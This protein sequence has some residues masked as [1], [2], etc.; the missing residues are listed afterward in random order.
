ML[1]FDAM[2]KTLGV[3]RSDPNLPHRSNLCASW[4]RL[5][6][7]FGASDLT[8]L[9]LDSANTRNTQHVRSGLSDQQPS[10]SKCR[11]LLYIIQHKSITAQSSRSQDY[12]LQ[13]ILHSTSLTAPGPRPIVGKEN[14]CKIGNV[15]NVYPEA[16][17]KVHIPRG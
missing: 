5:D 1:L 12:S 2:D 11:I 15:Q 17:V 16:F 14:K 10:N 6:F 4:R 3:E 13:A 7:L 8:I 9:C